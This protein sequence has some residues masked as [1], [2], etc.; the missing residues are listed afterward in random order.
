MSDLPNFAVIVPAAFLA[1]GALILFWGLSYARPARFN[2]RALRRWRRTLANAQFVSFST[3][4]TDTEIEE[5]A[6][7]FRRQQLYWLAGAGLGT[8][9]AMTLTLVGAFVAPDQALVNSIFSS[10]Y[11]VALVGTLTFQA[12]SIGACLGYRQHIRHYPV[13]TAL[14]QGSGGA[15]AESANDAEVERLPAWRRISTYRPWYV[16]LTPYGFLALYTSFTIVGAFRLVHAPITAYSFDIGAHAEQFFATH[17]WLLGLPIGVAAL[18][19]AI[20][21]RAIRS[22]VRSPERR[23]AATPQVSRHVNLGLRTTMVRTA[24]MSSTL[25]LSGQLFGLAMFLAR[26]FP[27]F[28]G[29]F[30]VGSYVLLSFIALQLSFGSVVFPKVALTEVA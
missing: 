18:N 26:F 8:I 29:A 1:L 14:P 11:G 13:V 21:E 23:Y 5:L 6:G 19:F 4:R 16:A 2:G 24:A 10:M 17:I 20:V 30:I 15:N 28:L 3:E 7:V 22:F 9:I 25:V 12:A 27:L